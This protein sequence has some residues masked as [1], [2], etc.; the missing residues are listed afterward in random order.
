MNEQLKKRLVGVVVL[1]ALAVV[2]VSIMLEGE[3]SNDIPISGSNVPE[4]PAKAVPTIDIPLQIPPPIA[5]KSK[6]AEK[7]MPA[8][9]EEAATPVQTAPPGP[10]VEPIIAAENKQPPA[11]AAVVAE[12]VKPVDVQQ[13]SQKSAAAESW[14]VQIGSF[15]TK[16]NANRLR[17]SLRAKGYP[18]YVEQVSLSGGLSYRVR[19]GPMLSRSDAEAAQAKLAEGGHRGIVMPHP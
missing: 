14:A 5:E 3:R 13:I 10:V 4:M 12:P 17:D 2:L 1:T 6:V 19:V 8:E 15:S 7:K 18:A 16:A 9:V 11:T